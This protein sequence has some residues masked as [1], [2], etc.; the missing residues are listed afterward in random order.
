LG[1]GFYGGGC[2]DPSIECK[3]EQINELVFMHY[4]C[5]MVVGV[6][7]QASLE[8]LMVEFGL[9]MQPFNLDYSHYE[10]PVTKSWLKSIWEKVQA[11]HLRIEF[12]S[13]DL[14]LPQEGDAWLMEKLFCMQFDKD[15]LARLNREHLHQQVLF[16][17]DILDARGMAIDRKYL[18]R[19]PQSERWSTITF[20][21]EDPPVRDFK[22]WEHAIF[23]RSR[24]ARSRKSNDL[25]TKCGTGNLMQ[26]QTHF[27]T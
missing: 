9:A 11:I 4:C 6:L 27:I 22:L 18:Q 21:L 20:P 19:C 14:I 17:L 10:G 26:R 3:V 2:P 24:L 13:M 23:I 1:I 25:V 5:K 12:G 15:E 7:L 16:L 8:F